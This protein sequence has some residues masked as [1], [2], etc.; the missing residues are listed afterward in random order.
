MN[1]T[2]ST[3]NEMTAPRFAKPRTKKPWAETIETIMR[4]SKY[5]YEQR[6]ILSAEQFAS[7]AR[8]Q[9]GID[10]S[11]ARKLSG[12]SQHK[13]ISDSQYW[14]ALPPHWALLYELSYLPDEMLLQ[15]ITEGSLIHVSKYDIWS[16]RGIRFKKTKDGALRLDNRM[17]VKAPENVSLVDH[18]RSG[19]ELERSQNLQPG[20]AAAVIGVA[21]QSYRQIRSLILLDER[22]DL[23]EAD[24]AAVRDAL[25]QI[26]KTRNVR[27]YYNRVKPIVERMWGTKREKQSNTT[28]NKRVESFKDAIGILGYA[29]QKAL[30]IELPYMSESD[31]AA[32]VSELNEARRSISQL[33]EKVR[34]LADE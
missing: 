25:A 27:R 18:C 19:L 10:S 1:P 13:I 31:I 12:L 6:Q 5:L 34:R 14:G 9:F 20:E 7:I 33:M 8:V 24:A 15:K 17:V 22:D 2:I 21:I 23:L 4:A 11:A 32:S 28:S 26:D 30:N 3:E 29:C 16:W